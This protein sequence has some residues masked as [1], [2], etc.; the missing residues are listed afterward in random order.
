MDNAYKMKSWI[1]FIIG[2]YFPGGKA[3]GREADHSSPSSVKVKNGGTVPPLPH[4]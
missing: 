2:L 3:A 4:T 1:F